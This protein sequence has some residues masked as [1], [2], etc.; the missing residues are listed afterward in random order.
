MAELNTAHNKST[1]KSGT[2]KQMCALVQ[3]KKQALRCEN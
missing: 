2:H 1:G 3:Y